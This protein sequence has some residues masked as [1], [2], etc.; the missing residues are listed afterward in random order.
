MRFFERNQTSLRGHPAEIKHKAGHREK[1]SVAGAI[2]L[3]PSRDRLSFSYHAL[4]NGLDGRLYAIGGL[5]ETTVEAYTPATNSWTFV[6]PMPAPQVDLRSTLV[7]AMA[8]SD[9][10]AQEEPARPPTGPDAPMAKHGE[11]CGGE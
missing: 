11:R 9:H 1:V 2:W 10:R 5:N 4:V 7:R 3:T 6:A 8:F